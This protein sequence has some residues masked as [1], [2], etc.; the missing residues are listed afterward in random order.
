MVVKQ[1]KY[2]KKDQQS[3]VTLR[4]CRTQQNPVTLDYR[5]GTQ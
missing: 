4:E 2:N 1:E 5:K 3:K